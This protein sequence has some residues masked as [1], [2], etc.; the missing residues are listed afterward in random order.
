VLKKFFPLIIAVF[1]L[2]FCATAESPVS[3]LIPG[4]K[5]IGVTLS[6]DGVMVVNV[7]DIKTDDNKS[8]SPARIAGIK[9]G[10]LI[11]KFNGNSISDVEELVSAVN[12]SGDKSSSVVIQ[13]GEKTIETL[14]TP[15]YSYPDGSLKI[16]AWIKD[17][18][19]G[20][21]TLTFYNP[22]DSTFGALGHGI[23]DSET[24]CIIPLDK[25]NIISSTIVNVEKGSRG[26]PGE[27]KGV[28]SEDSN[29]LGTI[30]K[31]TAHGIFGVSDNN[32]LNN[33]ISPLPVAMRSETTTGSAYILANV[34]GSNVEKFDIEIIRLMPPNTS[35]SKDMIIRITDEKLLQKTGGI[36]QGMSG[37]PIIQ[38]DKIVGAVTHV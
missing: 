32:N 33:T 26:S 7:A 34:E 20:I 8:E 35:C 22:A 31:N 17:A 28:F 23:C 11:K 14:I 16:G 4:G 12:N 29:I 1:S 9:P 19:S 3:Q 30:N 10:D 24:G 6:I 13:R 15:K 36:V 21:G 25:G 2:F 27:L 37:S 5:S 38:N 18:A